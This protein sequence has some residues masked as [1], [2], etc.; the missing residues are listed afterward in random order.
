MDITYAFLARAAEVNSDGTLSVLGADF[1]L[2]RAAGFPRECPMAV[3]VKLG[4]VPEQAELYAQLDIRGPEGVQIVTTPEPVPL[5]PIGR[6]S[7]VGAVT[8]RDTA[9][10]IVGLAGLVLPAPGEYTFHLRLTGDGTAER[11]IGLTAEVGD[12]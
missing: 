11:V 6:S 1:H 4:G 3:V 7:E 12:G 8:R 10:V 9:N 2:V 5:K